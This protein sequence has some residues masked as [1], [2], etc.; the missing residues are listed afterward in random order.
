ML[1][2]NAGILLLGG[3]EEISFDQWRRVQ[4]INADGVFLGVKYAVQLMNRC[5][6]RNGSI[7]NLC[8]IEGLIG[9]PR[10]AAYNA[11]KGAVK[12]LTKSVALD[13]A[14]KGTGIRVNSVC[15][16]YIETP[17]LQVIA[18]DEHKA[19]KDLHPIGR[20]GEPEEVANVILFLASDESSF[21]TGTEVVVDGGYTAQ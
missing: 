10:L 21:M 20:L 12:L 5:Q 18:D 19:L 15:P 9:D 4:S 2:N 13:Q 8:S 1:V 7:I 6:V 17:L 14:K 3:V 16:A 11:S